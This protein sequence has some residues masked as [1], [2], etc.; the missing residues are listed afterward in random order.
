MLWVKFLCAII[1]LFT[2]LLFFSDVVTMISDQ[3]VWIPKEGEAD[4]AMRHAA[5]RLILAAIMALTWP[6][7]FIF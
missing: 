3:S 1:A 2:T 6:V 4:P 7:L 5:F